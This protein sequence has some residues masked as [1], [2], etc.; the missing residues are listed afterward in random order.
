MTWRLKKLPVD[1]Q[2]GVFVHVTTN[3]RFGAVPK[4]VAV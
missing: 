3:W 2:S 1:P 4:A